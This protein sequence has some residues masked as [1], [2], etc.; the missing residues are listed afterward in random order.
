MPWADDR[1]AEVEVARR[2]RDA[3]ERERVFVVLFAQEFS[4]L[5]RAGRWIIVT[6]R[7][8]TAF[9]AYRRGRAKMTEER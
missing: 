4:E 1:D 7:E 2:H 6:D 3:D 5:F 8:V 9:L